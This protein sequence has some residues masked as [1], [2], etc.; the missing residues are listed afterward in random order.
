MLSWSCGDLLVTAL[1]SS[2]EDR[3][4]VSVYVEPNQIPRYARAKSSEGKFFLVV[5]KRF[6]S[7]GRNDRGDEQKKAGCRSCDRHPAFSRCVQQRLNCALPSFSLSPGFFRFRG[8]HGMS[9][10]EP[11]IHPACLAL[12]L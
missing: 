8:L 12:Y 11:L 4:F 2:Y 7:F 3:T 6:L 9:L 5:S 10:D 1:L